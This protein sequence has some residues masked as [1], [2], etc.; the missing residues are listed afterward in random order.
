[1]HEHLKH[2]YYPAGMIECECDRKSIATDNCIDPLNVVVLIHQPPPHEHVR[3]ICKTCSIHFNSP[4]GSSLE[5]W[6]IGKR[7]S[8][9]LS[10][11]PHF[12][13]AARYV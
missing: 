2:Y 5:P 1:M 13:L 3:V 7:V 4:F 9:E 6:G 11:A 8:N 12:M 10:C